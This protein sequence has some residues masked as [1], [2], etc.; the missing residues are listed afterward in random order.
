MSIYKLENYSKKK[1]NNINRY[2]TKINMN[3]KIISLL[4]VNWLIYLTVAISIFISPY[5]IGAYLNQVNNHF[6]LLIYPFLVWC[7][8]PLAC[9]FLLLSLLALFKPFK[10]KRVFYSVHDINSLRNLDW[11]EFETLTAQIM[12]ALHYKVKEQGGAKAD[13]GIDLIA[14]KKDYKYIIQCKH[15]KTTTVGV[16]IVREMLGVSIHEKASGVYIFTCG[17]FTKEAIAF[18]KEKR[19]YLV[20]GQQ[21]CRL[22]DKIKN[23]Q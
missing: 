8:I 11:R 1:I 12:R 13:G 3:R 10:K 19:V 15:W 2:S 23:Q 17:K 21:I 9:F 4:N 14:Y 16:K 7:S 6:L 22:I 20:N 18:A 5:V